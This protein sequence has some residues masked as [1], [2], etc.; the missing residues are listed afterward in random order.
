MKLI[1][2]LKDKIIG[3]YIDIMKNEEKVKGVYNGM[4][5]GRFVVKAMENIKKGDNLEIRLSIGGWNFIFPCSVES[6][7][8]NETILKP[9]GKVKIKEKRK[10]KRVPILEKCV[11]NN[12]KGSLLDV[13]F[14][15][16]RI[17]TLGEFNM[18]DVV[19][20]NVNGNTTKGTVRWMKSEEV[21]LKSVGVLI[22][23]VDPW[24]KD[25]VKKKLSESMNVLRRM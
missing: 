18:G 12:T 11:I 1:D 6:V 4:R 5:N 10:E 2:L 9:L 17:L 13:S 21:D 3:M 8:E 20:I 16:I 25:Y 7:D 19:E 14:H 24:W 15:G 22:E 23:D